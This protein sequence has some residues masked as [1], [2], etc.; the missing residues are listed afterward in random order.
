MFHHLNPNL[1]SDFADFYELMHEQ[2]RGNIEVVSLGL[3]PEEL[4]H[5]A[6]SGGRGWLS[7]DHV[8]WVI[9]QLNT[10]QQETMLICPNAV[11]NIQEK[12]TCQL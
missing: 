4:S 1:T 7:T 3:T 9:S 2:R 8:V 12:K 6:A 5:L 11:V 10:V